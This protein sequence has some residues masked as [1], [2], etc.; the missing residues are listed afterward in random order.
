MTESSI[1][2]EH[3]VVN[4]RCCPSGTYCPTEQI[5]I[6]STNIQ[7]YIY[8]YRDKVHQINFQRSSSIKLGV[9]HKKEVKAK[10]EL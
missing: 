3:T 9:L 8:I 7:I 2:G 1:S 6:F 5:V 10:A 4:K